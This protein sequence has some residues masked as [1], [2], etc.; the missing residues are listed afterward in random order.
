MNLAEELLKLQ[1]DLGKSIRDTNER[2]RKLEE[3]LGVLLSKIV[4]E[5]NR[6]R[7][8]GIKA[9]IG[10]TVGAMMTNGL[11]VKIMEQGIVALQ[12]YR[13]QTWLTHYV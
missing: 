2:T 11:F 5:E 13:G 10:T 9:L 7:R 12:G 6:E 3:H 8:M 1:E 4:G